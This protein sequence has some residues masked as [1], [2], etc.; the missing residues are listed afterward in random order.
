MDALKV[1]AQSPVLVTGCTGFK[2]AWLCAWL[3]ELGANVT[4]YSLPPPTTPSLFEDAGLGSEMEWVNGDVRDTAHF[5]KTLERVRP[6][7]VFHLAAASLVRASYDNPVETF[8]INVMGTVS[9]M[10]ALRDWKAPLAAVLI[11]TDKVYE[12]LERDV[13]FQE[14]DA[15]G[16]KDPYSASKAA[17][18]IAIGSFRSS[19][20]QRQDSWVRLASARAGN[21]IG[22]GDWAKD[23][24][25]PDAI[26]ALAQGNPLEVRNPSS[27]RP[28]QHVLEPLAGYLLLGAKIAAKDGAPFAAAF[29]FGPR[30][31]DER[32]VAELADAIVQ[33]W[34]KGQWVAK[35]EANAPVEAKSL[36]LSSAKARRELGWTPVWTFDDAVSRTVRFYGG[37]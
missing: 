13:S 14:S 32:T 10:E 27:I 1:Y 35:P 29:N 4:G 24:L 36:K 25:V 19:F 34:G 16:G 6:R 23:R 2:G 31:E 11:S 8:D 18:E 21:V 37:R 20:F 26:R 7:F 15:L 22:G 9:V 33:Y 3:R 30:A 28:W 12:N 5:R 17:M